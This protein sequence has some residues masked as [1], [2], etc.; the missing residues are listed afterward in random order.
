MPKREG[1]EG[2]NHR[3]QNEH[4]IQHNDPLAI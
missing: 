4:G 3:T 1:I 2:E